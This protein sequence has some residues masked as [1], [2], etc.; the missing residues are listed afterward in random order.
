MSYL[1]VY[2]FCSVGI[3]FLLFVRGRLFYRPNWLSSLLLHMIFVVLIFDVL[4]LWKIKLIYDMIYD[5]IDI[6]TKLW[7]LKFPF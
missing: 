2:I 7:I 6:C 3:L 4:Y 5:M 1:V